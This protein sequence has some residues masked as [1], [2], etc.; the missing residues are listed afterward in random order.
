MLELVQAVGT[1]I[2]DCRTEVV[3]V[4]CDDNEDAHCEREQELDPEEERVSLDE[5]TVAYDCTDK[6]EEPEKSKHGPH[7]TSDDHS[8]LHTT[9]E[10]YSMLGTVCE[11]PPEGERSTSRAQESEEGEDEHAESDRQAAAEVLG[12]FG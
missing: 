5:A 7:N 1:F 9:F 10:D 2:N 6:A 11:D 4:E 3:L 8:S 12:H